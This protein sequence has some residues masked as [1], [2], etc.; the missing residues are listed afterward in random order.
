VGVEV[1]DQRVGPVLGVDRIAEY[2]QRVTVIEAHAV[3]F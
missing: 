2:L 1:A 3:A